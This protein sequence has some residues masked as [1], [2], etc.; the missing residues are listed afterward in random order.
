MIVQH[1]YQI[2]IEWSGRIHGTTASY[3]S[4]SREYTIKCKG[5][6]DLICSSDQLYRGQPDLYN[7]EDLFVST[8]SSCHMLWYLH[9]AADHGIHVV[10]YIDQASGVMQV[11]DDGGGR[12]T[13]VT[14]RPQVVIASEQDA[15]LAVDLHKEAHHKCFIANSVNFPVD[16]F[17]VINCDS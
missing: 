17:P 7:P 3:T 4:Y 13:N 16:C 1:P 6:A 14:L 10:S 15:A 11:D 9:L 12:F 8:I 2:T 5:K